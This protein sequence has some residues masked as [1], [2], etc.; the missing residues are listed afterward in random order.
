MPT[1]TNS[2]FPL[3]KSVT[4]SV[5]IPQT[6]LSFIKQIINPFN[7]KLDSTDLSNCSVDCHCCRS[8]D[9][10]TVMYGSLWLQDHTHVKTCIC[11]RIEFP[12]SAPPACSLAP[13]NDKCPMSGLSHHSFFL[14]SLVRRF[15]FII[16]IYLN[17]RIIQK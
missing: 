2:M 12:A 15:Q 17:L 4:A 5:R 16:N 6:F 7:I 8:C 10:Q 14:G 9:Q 11:R 1:T 3:S 13:G